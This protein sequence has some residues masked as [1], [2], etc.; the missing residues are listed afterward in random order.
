[1]GNTS[2]PKLK[3]SKHN[4][5]SCV[6]GTYG[7]ISCTNTQFTKGVSFHYFPKNA[8]RHQQ[9]VLCV[10]RHRPEFKPSRYSSLCSVHFEDCCYSAPRD[11]ALQFR[12]RAKL[13]DDAVPRVVYPAC[14]APEVISMQAGSRMTSSRGPP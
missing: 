9:W 12:I 8:K 13:K 11:A 2:Q 1:M 10:R 14:L 4:G 6:A 7:G 3:V 5:R